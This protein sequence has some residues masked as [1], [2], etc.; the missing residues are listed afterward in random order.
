MQWHVIQTCRQRRT[1]TGICFPYNV[2][3]SPQ[4]QLEF[5]L[6]NK[7]PL[8]HLQRMTSNLGAKCPSTLVYTPEK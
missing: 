3:G 8:S 1:V 6:N 4:H 5:P 7:I 2:T